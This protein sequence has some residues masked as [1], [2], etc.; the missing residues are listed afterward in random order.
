[1]KP[2]LIY[3]LLLFV[4]LALSGC[5][6]RGR[7]GPGVEVPR[8]DSVLGPVV[9]YQQNCAGCHGA[10]GRPGPAMAPSDPVYLALVDDDTLRTTIS[11]GRKG[12]AMSAFAQKEGGM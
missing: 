2:S 3:A 8:P 10:G 6:L 5:Q 9:L 12:T 7:P 11:K 1:M 4:G